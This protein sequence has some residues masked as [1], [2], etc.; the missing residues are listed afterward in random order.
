M[1]QGAIQLEVIINNRNISIKK[2]NLVSLK[3]SRVIGDAANSFTLE[4]FDDTAWQLENAIMGTSL[5]PITIRYSASN[6][7]NNSR[8]FKAFIYLSPYNLLQL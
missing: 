2:E 7:L 3:V 4:V 1:N 8:L 6:S 5:A